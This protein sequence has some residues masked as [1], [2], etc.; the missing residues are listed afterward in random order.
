MDKVEGVDKVERQRA[1]FDRVSTT[2]FAEGYPYALV[3]NLADIMFKQLGASLEV[4]GLTS[5]FHLPWNLKFVWGPFVDEY[6]TKRGWLLTTELAVVVI[7]ALIALAASFDFSSLWPLAVGFLV[8]AF[9][10]FKVNSEMGL[11]S[12]VTIAI[13]LA[14]DFFFLPPLLMKLEPKKS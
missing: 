3:N 1:H 9:S 14:A 7:T 2:Y 8:L 13:A 12:A 11:L 10:G 5:L 6:G 4:V